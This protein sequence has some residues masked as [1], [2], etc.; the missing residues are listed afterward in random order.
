[1]AG[2]FRGCKGFA[3]GRF[4]ILAVRPLRVRLLVVLAAV[5]AVASPLESV[6]PAQAAVASKVSLNLSPSVA[7]PD[8]SFVV[9]GAVSP[10]ASGR[11]VWL[12][13]HGSSWST[14]LSVKTNSTGHF[15]GS[16]QAGVAGSNTSWRAVALPFARTG[17]AL[18]PTRALSVVKAALSLSA[19]LLAETNLDFTISGTGYPAREG[20]MVMVQRLSGSSWT[21]VGSATQSSTGGYSVKTSMSTG[22]EFT[23]RAVTSSWHGAAAVTL[24]DQRGFSASPFLPADGIDCDRIR[25]GQRH[26]EAAGRVLAAD[27]GSA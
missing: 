25:D 19:P 10:A 3:V 23:Y 11:T 18:S 27:F 7:A 20:R 9:S 13:S 4:G 15:S 16:V 17:Q 8:E 14:V 26:R 24:C 5:L 6:A 12:Q 2:S 21:D 22:G 1:M